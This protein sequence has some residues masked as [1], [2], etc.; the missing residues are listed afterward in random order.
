[1]IHIFCVVEL[2]GHTALKAMAT[3][4]VGEVKLLDCCIERSN[5]RPSL[6]GY[7]KHG[8]RVVFGLDCFRR[9]FEVFAVTAFMSTDVN[10]ERLR[11]ADCGGRGVG[12]TPCPCLCLLDW[13]AAMQN[14]KS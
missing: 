4:R 5:A 8:K 3:H 1:M 9:A 7:Q 6:L 10:C 12:A 14:W 11:C 2:L 13:T